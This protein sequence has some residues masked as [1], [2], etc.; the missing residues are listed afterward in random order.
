VTTFPNATGKWQVS[1][2]RG[3]EPRW[4]ADDK[5]IFYL[6]PKG[7]LTAVPVNAEGTFTTGIPTPLFSL[8]ARPP[9]T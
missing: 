1:R 5:D 9:P 8:H 2:G 4:R 7:M 3:T 6:D